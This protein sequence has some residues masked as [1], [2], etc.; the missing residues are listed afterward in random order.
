MMPSLRRSRRTSSAR[1]GAL[2]LAL[3]LALA[4]GCATP[5]LAERRFDAPY[6]RTFRAAVRAL[7]RE[8]PPVER[9]DEAAGRIATG[10]H[11]A[12]APRT[13][14]YLF[15]G[16]FVERRRF[17]LEVWP[18]GARTAVAVHLT[19]EE[20]APGGTGAIRWARAAPRKELVDALFARIE[21]ELEKP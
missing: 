8:A 5:P 6:A 20:R 10:F 12:L 7:E 21:E 18:E 9:A 16:Y 14:G 4:A 19:L 1:L 15:E 13:R 17:A 11:E 3:P 2:A